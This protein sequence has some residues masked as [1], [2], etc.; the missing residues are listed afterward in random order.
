MH[1]S[2][3]KPTWP[4]LR[5]QTH[6]RGALDDVSVAHGRRP[7]LSDVGEAEPAVPS[8]RGPSFV[9]GS[10]RGAL[11]GEAGRDRPTP[12]PAESALSA[13]TST[14]CSGAS[15]ARGM[16]PGLASRNPRAD[17]A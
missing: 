17:G 15:S 10:G 1:Q 4:R 2:E 13:E 16:G 9:A 6:R 11:D 14:S 12:P 5:A 8:A 3:T 7:A